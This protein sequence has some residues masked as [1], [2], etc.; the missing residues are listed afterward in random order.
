MAD[1]LFIARL[2]L[3]EGVSEA[4]LKDLIDG[5]RASNP[6]VLTGREANQI[7]QANQVQEDRVGQLIDMVYKKGDVAS[8]L[9]ISILEAKDQ[10][11]AENLKL[12]TEEDI[13]GQRRILITEDNLQ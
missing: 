1:Q 5:L 2:G 4:L 7:L 8:V 9:M 3:I 10:H 13:S 11:L 6:P 12:R